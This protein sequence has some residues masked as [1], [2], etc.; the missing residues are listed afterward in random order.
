MSPHRK[1]AAPAKPRLPPTDAAGPLSLAEDLLMGAAAIS[2]FMFG[3][4]DDR[5]KVYWMAESGQLPV[6]RLGAVL[7]ARRSSILRVLE[8]HEQSATAPA[9][10]RRDCEIENQ[11]ATTD[12]LRKEPDREDRALFAFSRTKPRRQARVQ[13]K[14]RTCLR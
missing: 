9:R 10:K 14:G 3:T 2:M 11:A 1:D 6:F 8:L 13:Q 5:R 12:A 7:C 4:P